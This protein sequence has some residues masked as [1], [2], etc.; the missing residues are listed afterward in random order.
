MLLLIILPKLLQLTI[1]YVNMF[2]LAI[3]YSPAD[4]DLT[5]ISHVFT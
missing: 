2:P 5:S 1:I 4:Q 3:A